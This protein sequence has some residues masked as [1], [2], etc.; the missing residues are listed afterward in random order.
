VDVVEAGH[1]DVARDAAPVVAQMGERPDGHL[2]GSA[3]DGGQ[4]RVL[5]QQTTGRVVALVPGRRTVVDDQPG[6][7]LV[8]GL[9]EPAQPLLGRD[10]CG[11]P[12]DQGDVA[13]AELDQV[14]AQHPAS[15]AVVDQHAVHV[16]HRGAD[17]D[18]APAGGAEGPDA[19]GDAGAVALVVQSGAGQDHRV[20]PVGLQH[21]E[22]PQLTVRVALGVA[23]G[24]QQVL[25]SGTVVDAVDDLG[26]VRVAHIADQHS[27]GACV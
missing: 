3:G 17:G 26:E 19:G 23:D 27:D 22:V 11:G 7:G 9:L 18:H 14:P 2:V 12:G 5:L 15:V 10:Q 13:V 24:H 6:T 1:G 25:G 8:E 4:L 16:D 20:G 21:P